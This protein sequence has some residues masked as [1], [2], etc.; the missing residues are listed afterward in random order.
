MEK[1]L[2]L[3]MEEDLASRFRFFESE[4]ALP[5]H[6]LNLKNSLKKSKLHTI[7]S[8]LTYKS[9][10]RCEYNKLKPKLNNLQKLFIS[11]PEG[12]IA[13]NIIYFIRK[14]FPSIKIISLQHGIFALRSPSSVKT[15][16]KKV[17]NTIMKPILGYFPVGDGFGEKSTDS[18]IVYN[19]RYKKYLLNLGWK[20]NQV[21]ISSYFLKGEKEVQKIDSP[22]AN[23]AVFFLQCLHKLGIADFNTEMKLIENVVGKLS[24]IYSEVLIKQHPYA[25]I[26]LPVLPKNT[27]VIKE[28]PELSEI[29]I[30]VSAFSTALLEYEKYGIKAVSL[31]SKKL[32]VDPAVYDQFLYVYDLDE[33]STEFTYKKNPKRDG[34]DVFFEIGITDLEQL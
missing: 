2:F 7:V 34:L 18:Y 14:D 27:R 17:V 23:K 22:H 28:V 30:V 4:T 26:D 31:K 33:M 13:K 24:K 21:N 6:Q 16:L 20:E 9:N 8:R 1:A 19:S 25:D 11:N 12:Y 5:V 29:A 15:I 3:I 10:L 32:N